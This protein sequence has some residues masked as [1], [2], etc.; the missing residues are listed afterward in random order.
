VST[1]EHLA[2]FDWYGPH[3]HWLRNKATGTR[4]DLCGANL[5]EANLSWADLCGAIGIHLLTQTNHGYQVRAQWRSG[6]WRIV[7]GCRDLSVSEAR[8]HWGD[9]HYH[10]PSS[11]SRIVA[12]LDWLEKQPA[13]TSEAAA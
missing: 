1:P 4:A 8:E 3:Q 6:E 13:P 9:P 11:G 7:A 5:R 10:T 12:L 2:K